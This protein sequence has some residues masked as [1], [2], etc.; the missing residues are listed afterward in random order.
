M[1]SIVRFSC[2]VMRKRP[3][4]E[5]STITRHMHYTC[6]HT[7]TNYIYCYKLIYVYTMYAH[8]RSMS[9]SDDV[10]FRALLRGTTCH[11]LLNLADALEVS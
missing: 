2:M 8:G 7:W 5:R 11:I 9:N 1:D 10:D 6:I 3:D 4:T